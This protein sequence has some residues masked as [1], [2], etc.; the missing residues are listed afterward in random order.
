MTDA[1]NMERLVKVSMKIKAK[2]AEEQAA[3]DAVEKGLK[4][5]LD[6][7]TAEIKDALKAQGLESAR[8]AYGLVT[9]KTTR[10]YYAQDWDAM[11]KFMRDNDL[12]AL[13]EKRIAQRN[14]QTFLDENPGMV[15]PGLNSMSELTVSITSPRK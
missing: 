5:Q 14:M 9:L 3:F 15:P 1:I 2:L 8:T 12:L 10:R 4:E 6:L 7:V 11:H 13:L